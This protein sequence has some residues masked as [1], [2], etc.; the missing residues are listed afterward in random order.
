M[1][2]LTPQEVARK[3]PV[4]ADGNM[5]LPPNVRIVM[6]QKEN[7]LSAMAKAR[8]AFKGVKTQNID[9]MEI[10]NGKVFIDGVETKE[11]IQGVNLGNRAQ[12]RANAKRK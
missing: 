3:Y 10:R 2:N 5:N 9:N 1:K 8:E 4:D 12:R 6:P 11:P 7:A